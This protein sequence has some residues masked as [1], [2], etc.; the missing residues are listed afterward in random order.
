MRRSK[1]GLMSFE[2]PADLMVSVSGVRGRV[3]EGLT[4]EVVARFAAA[5]GAFLHEDTGGR[6]GRRPRVV[7]ARDARTSGPMFYDT[8]SAA[9][10][11]VGVD[12]VAI[13]LAPTPT[14]LYAIRHHDA[15]GA[16]VVTASH[17][18]VEWNALKFASR[19]GMFLDGDQ[20]ARQQAYVSD[21]PIPRAGWD[22]LGLVSTD[23]DAPRRHIDAV[24]A[25][26]YLDID[27]LRR[28]RFKVAL[29]C[30]RGAGSVL[31]PPLLE[32]LGCDVV[33]LN[34]E[35]DGRFPRE[36]EPVPE[37]LGELE[38]LVRESG[39]DVGL[40]T[41]P[42]ADRLALVSN[43]G[44]AIGEDFTLT[45][46]AQLVLRHRSGP[47]VTNLS[48][49]RLLED[50]AEANGVRLE[51]APVGEINVARAMQRAGAVIGGEGNGGVILP[52][53][54]LTRDSAVAAALVLQLMLELDM[55]LAEIAGAHR[56]YS[57]VKAKL[58]RDAGSLDQAYGKLS[59]RLAAPESDRQDGL[60]L[61]WPAEG[62]WLH[63]RASGTEPIL[64]IIA[65]APTAE[66]ARE[67][68]DQAREALAPAS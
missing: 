3:G 63:L 29:E 39:A 46:A 4:P 35:P 56:V 17:N 19:E 60:R 49:S 14:A 28:R 42:D 26:P 22:G 33:G 34:L 57:I 55:T 8:V 48:T 30:I 15:D 62:T 67:L 59:D 65:E 50:L 21:R 5:Y 9:L 52:E 58:P 37:N 40:A 25:L 68:I 32:A 27:G 24:L 10:R 18:P 20:A 53:I 45:L 12:V 7:L 47:V 13:G 2:I 43:E 23:D 38:R 6:G 51:R 61:A 41:D 66:Q 11:S 16:I 1:E 31:L 36:P 64:R 54:Q 44:R